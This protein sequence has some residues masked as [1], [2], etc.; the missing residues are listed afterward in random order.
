MFKY[1]DNRRWSHSVLPHIV[2]SLVL[3][4]PFTA[5]FFATAIHTGSLQIY[6]LSFS[7]SLIFGLFLTH[8]AQTQLLFPTVEVCSQ[9]LV[10]NL[11]ISKRAVYNLKQIE[12]ARFFWHIL[13][14]RHMGWPVLTPLPKMPVEAKKQLLSMLGGS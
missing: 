8:R 10:L 13:Y 9:H 2:V 14:F 5:L 7:F 6:L 11:P 12:G 3:W 4:L 1:Q